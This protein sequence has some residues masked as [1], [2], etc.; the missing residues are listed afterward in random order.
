MKPQT[1]RHYEIGVKHHFTENLRGDVTLFRA[2]IKDEIFYNPLTMLNANYPETLHK[3][4]ELGLRADFIDKVTIIGNYTYTD[5]EFE[6]APLKNNS[7]PAVPEHTVHIGVSVYDVVPGCRLSV[8]YNYVG[9]SYYISDQA[10]TQK[11]L[12]DYSTVDCKLSYTVKGVEAFFGINNL[13]NEEY[14]EYGVVGFGGTRNSYP[15]PE[16]NWFLGFNVAL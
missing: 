1:G 13:T 8:S 14:S 10:N 4:V 6:K 7:I 9:E 12:D 16:R 2:E 3:G 15:S 5:A 11:K